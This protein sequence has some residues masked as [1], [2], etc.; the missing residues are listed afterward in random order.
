MIELDERSWRRQDDIV[1]GLAAGAGSGDHVSSP[2]FTIS[3]E[4]DAGHLKIYHFDFYRLQEAG[5]MADELAE[6]AGKPDTVVIIEWGDVARH[7]LP[8]GSVTIEILALSDLKRRLTFT[9][10]DERAYLIPRE[11]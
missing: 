1:R 7:V 10:P 3:Q 4:Y 5:V 8:H 11:A 2:T 6:V 9:Y